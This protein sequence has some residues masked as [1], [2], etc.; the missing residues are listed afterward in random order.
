MSSSTSSRILR[1]CSTTPRSRINEKL[2]PF[3]LYQYCLRPSCLAESRPRYERR[4]FTVSHSS[5]AALAS[6]PPAQSTVLLAYPSITQNG[7]DEYDE[8]EADIDLVPL[9]EAQIEITDRAAEVRLGHLPSSVCS[10][11]T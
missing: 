11:E 4:T 6:H 1:L 2:L 10:N 7:R 8:D 3:N 5:R 9:E